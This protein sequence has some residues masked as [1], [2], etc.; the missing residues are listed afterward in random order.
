MSDHTDGPGAAAAGKKRMVEGHAPGGPQ[1]KH[2]QHEERGVT[3]ANAL[4]VAT[5]PA[6]YPSADKKPRK[7]PSL[8]VHQR[9]RST[10]EDCGGSGLCE[11]QRQRGACVKTVVAAV[12]ASTRGRGASAKTVAATVSASTSGRK[13]S[14]KTAAVTV[15]VSISA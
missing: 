4:G 7:A 12:S 13:A 5:T 8:C 11:H 14:A 9:R 6:S 10:C 3:I 15:S 1:G 2:S